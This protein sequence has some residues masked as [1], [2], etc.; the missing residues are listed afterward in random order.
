MSALSGE[1]LLSSNIRFTL[2]PILSIDKQQE[3][4]ANITSSGS[5][6]SGPKIRFCRD[7]SDPLPSQSY[8]PIAPPM[9]RQASGSDSARKRRR[10]DDNFA[11]RD[12]DSWAQ[13]RAEPP[14]H[15]QRTS[16]WSAGSADNGWES[17]HRNRASNSQ[18]GELPLLNDQDPYNRVPFE[19]SFEDWLRP[20]K[21]PH[22]SR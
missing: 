18:H 17:H 9:I 7:Y 14:N 2:N 5:L 6:V 10:N 3:L 1:C 12:R 4:A 11:Y 15:R 22:F 16:N 13:D 20:P 21:Q 19:F 8:N